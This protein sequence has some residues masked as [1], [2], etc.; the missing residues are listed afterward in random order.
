MVSCNVEQGRS[1]HYI[2]ITS[3]HC[4]LPGSFKPEDAPQN[5]YTYDEYEE[6][7]TFPDDD[8]E[9]WVSF[10]D[11]EEEQEPEIPDTPPSVPSTRA[12]TPAIP[13]EVEDV[14]DGDDERS[15]PSLNIPPPQPYQSIF[16][17]LFSSS[18]E[19]LSLDEFEA[20]NESNTEPVVA[21][22]PAEFSDEEEEFVV[23]EEQIEPTRVFRPIRPE[24][25]TPPQRS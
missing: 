12:C 11:E 24:M 10:D 23:A 1:T 15:E 5:Q 16:R 7:Y 6:T 13:P 9:D 22:P 4:Y 19:D 14:D 20:S 21:D 8:E 25:N 2:K 3:N 17:D 18:S